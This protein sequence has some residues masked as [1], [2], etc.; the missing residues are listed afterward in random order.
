MG[1]RPKNAS[2]FHINSEGK[3][4]DKYGREVITDWEAYEKLRGKRVA[5]SLCAIK[6]KKII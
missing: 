3:T 1:R 2:G 5:P 4:V 6:A